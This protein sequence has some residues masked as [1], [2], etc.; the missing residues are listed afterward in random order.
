MEVF[1]ASEHHKDLVDSFYEKVGYHSHWSD[2]E[3]AFISTSNDKIIGSVKVERIY[4]VSILRGMYLSVDF[5]KQGLGTKFIQHI[6]PV[7]NETESY[8]IPFSHLSAFY[9]QVGFQEIAAK[10]LPGFLYKRFIG[11]Q[12]LG[13]KIIA[14]R[15]QPKVL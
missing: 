14:M 1:E 9:A 11:Y 15:R 6:E 7:L 3:R 4:G 12:A 2:T 5:Q 10:S 8:C 13:Y